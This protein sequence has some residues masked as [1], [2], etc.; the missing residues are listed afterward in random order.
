MRSASWS[1]TWRL[2]SSKILIHTLGREKTLDAM[3]V[4][5]QTCLHLK[6]TLIVFIWCYVQS[7]HGQWMNSWK[8]SYL[9][10]RL[11]VFN[12]LSSLNAEPTINQFT[13]H[14]SP[15]CPSSNS[16]GAAAGQAPRHCPAR[17]QQ[18]WCSLSQWA[19]RHVSQQLW[20]SRTACARQQQQQQ[21]SW[22]LDV[23]GEAASASG[24]YAWVMF[25]T[26][27]RISRQ[28]QQACCFGAWVE[29]GS[30]MHATEALS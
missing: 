29:T 6:L 25:S 23:P 5:W 13:R 24:P 11:L 28:L 2:A 14:A 12:L 7:K 4:L 8:M 16:A 15:S 18:S 10:I 17:R 22:Q 26:A 30:S 3:R 9:F 21:Q 27:T 19:G 1:H 20:Q